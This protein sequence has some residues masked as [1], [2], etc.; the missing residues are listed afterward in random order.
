MTTARR[1]FH[2][3]ATAGTVTRV[4][5]AQPLIALTFDDGPDPMVTPALLEVLQSFRAQATFFM[6]GA[7]ADAHRDVVEGVAE[8][9]HE[10]GN[11]TWGHRP[12]PDLSWRA[13]WQELDRGARAL[14]PFGLRLLRPPCG[15]QTRG[16]YLAA[17]LRG[18]TVVAWSLAVQDWLQDAP[19]TIVHDIVARVR[20]GD[21]VLLHDGLYT[22]AGHREGGRGTVVAAVACLLE[23]LDGR[24]EPVGL[25]RLLRAGR[26]VRR[27]WLW[28]PSPPSLR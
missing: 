14:A 28:H 10:I 15:E 1:L 20:P 7:A 25:T 5:T 11:H 8:S 27:R 19:D 13:R 24:L 6:V 16:S 22:R 4:E 9:G 3:Y 26:V 12:L 2:R 17:R 18:Y 23:R 21:I